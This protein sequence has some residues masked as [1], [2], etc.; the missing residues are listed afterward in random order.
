MTY[1]IQQL[2]QLAG[3]S[4]RTLRYYDQIG[5]LPARRNPTNGYRT[6][7]ASAVD[8]LQL[9][10]YFQEFGFSLAQIQALLAQSPA[11]QTAAL[12]A[13]R[14]QLVANRDHLT[15]LLNTLDRTLAARNGGPQMTD[16][17]KFAAFKQQ[18][19][20]QNEQKFGEES[21]KRYGQTEFTA[22]QKKFAGLTETDYQAMQTTEE[23]LVTK[24][25]AVATT[26]DL[27][28]N[29]AHEVYDLHRQWLCFTWNNYSAEAHRGL[30][31]MYLDDDRFARYYNDR[32]GLANATETLVAIIQRYAH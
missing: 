7:S 29:T 4:P 13:Q 19:L 9:I 23:R 10:R 18:Q 16:T 28:S 20:A 6:Y 31:Q 11:E 24:L 1:S 8:Q 21:R 2:A 15:T 25:K 14:A 26:G 32:V 22:S 5:L 3:V 30:A 27:T 12:T 17:E